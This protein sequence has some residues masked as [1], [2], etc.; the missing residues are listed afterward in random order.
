MK[1][2]E[3]LH[4]HRDRVWSV[5]WNP[6]G[7][8]VASCGA[9]KTVRLWAKED[10]AGWKCVSTLDGS[11]SR[12]VRSVVWSPSGKMLATASFDGTTCVWKREEEEEGSTGSSSSDFE[13]IATLEGHANEVKC[14]DWSAG[15]TLLATCSRDKSV[16]I[17][18]VTDSSADDF[19][20]AAV[21]NSHSQDVKCVRWSPTEE[22]LCSASYDDTIKM[23]VE[24]MG[25]WVCSSTL[26]SHS[27]TV[28]SV[29]FDPRGERLVSASDDKT[30]KIWNRYLPGNDQGIATTG[31]NPTWKCVCTLSGFHDRPIYDVRWCKLSGLI[32][33][34]CGDDAIRIFEEDKNSSCVDFHQ[35]S[36]KL[37]C[38][39]DKAHSQEVNTLSWNPAV[40]GLLASCSDDGE[41]KLWKVTAAD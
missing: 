5:S 15:G 25:D 33:S 28:W 3:T 4:G 22:V 38:V 20:C 31:K 14:A 17:W 32:A 37:V 36:F 18:E 1:L 7:T 30:L 6:S 2:I 12:T 19:E 40:E 11:H 24:E 35:P 13:C 34:A 26:V 8:I 9:D 10:N 39:V 29:D 16:W 41:V 27:S 21:L 23:Y